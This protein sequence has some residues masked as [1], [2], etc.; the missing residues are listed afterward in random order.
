MTTK[1]KVESMKCMG[2]VAAVKKALEELDGVTSATVELEPG[3]A[4][5][6]GSFSVDAAIS[7]LTEIGYPASSLD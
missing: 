4:E 3:E 5:V 1:L 2:C 7:K 6:E